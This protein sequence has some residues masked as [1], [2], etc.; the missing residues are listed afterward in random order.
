VVRASDTERQAVVELLIGHFGDGRLTM[1]EVEERITEAWEARTDADLAFALRELPVGPAVDRE[2]HPRRRFPRI[3][4]PAHALIAASGVSVAYAI[5]MTGPTPGD[6]WPF[7][8]SIAWLAGLACHAGTI[9]L[10]RHWTM[11]SG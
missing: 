5:E 6:Q 4:L 9:G 1:E 2:R 3:T 8:L 10:R 11:A 7:A